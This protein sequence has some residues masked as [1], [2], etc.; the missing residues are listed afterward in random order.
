VREP[1]PAKQ[2]SPLSFSES[3]KTFLPSIARERDFYLVLAART[4]VTMGAFSILPFFQ[5]FF[6]DIMRDPQAV[7]HGS[8]LLAGITLATLPVALFAGKQADHRGPKQITLISGWVMSAA[9]AIYIFDC[10]VP[11]WPFTVVVGLAFGAASVAFQTVDWALALSVLPRTQQPGKDMGIWHTSFVLPQ[12]IAPLLAGAILD[13]SKHLSKATGYAIVF[14]MA[15]LW[16]ALGTAPI[17]QISSR[18]SVIGPE[19]ETAS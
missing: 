13:R 9:T 16:Y 12:T 6:S 2:V 19:G 8:L 3:L 17:A 1:P 10:F 18:R 7:L 5:Y 15:A 11:S 4:C 14:A